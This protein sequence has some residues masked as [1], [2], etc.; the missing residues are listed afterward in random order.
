MSY[1]AKFSKGA[2]KQF[3][4][5]SLDVQERIQTK[6]NDCA[7]VFINQP[8]SPEFFQIMGASQLKI[9]Q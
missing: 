4:K 8:H 3:R 2:K 6:I 5:L 7:Y 1:E 9:A